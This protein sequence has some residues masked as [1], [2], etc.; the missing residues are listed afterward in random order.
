MKIQD[1]VRNAPLVVYVPFM[2]AS[3]FVWVALVLFVGR[4]QAVAMWDWLTEI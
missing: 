2:V 4:K 3:F 1:F